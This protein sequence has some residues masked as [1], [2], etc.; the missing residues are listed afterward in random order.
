MEQ[1]S[2]WAIH[3]LQETMTKEESAYCVRRDCR[4][5]NRR[6]QTSQAGED[7]EARHHRPCSPLRYWDPGQ[8][9]SQQW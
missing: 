1:V 2:V 5:R 8:R 4:R 7:P 3:D 9:R 6:E